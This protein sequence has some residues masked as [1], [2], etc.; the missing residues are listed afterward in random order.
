MLIINS[1]DK[2]ELV[3]KNINQVLEILGFKTLHLA[4]MLNDEIIKKSKYNYIL[5]HG[6]KLEIVQLVAGG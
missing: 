3:G 6:D 5:K 2:S 1:H 4:V